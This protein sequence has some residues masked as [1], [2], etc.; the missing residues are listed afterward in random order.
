MA[1]A[2]GP[3]CFLY[4]LLL[5]QTHTLT[6]AHMHGCTHTLMYANLYPNIGR[7][8]WRLDCLTLS[9]TCCPHFAH[10]WEN[11]REATGTKLRDNSFHTSFLSPVSHQFLLFPWLQCEAVLGNLVLFL[12]MSLTPFQSPAWQKAQRPVQS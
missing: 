9:L 2:S 12:G 7:L 6:H 8:G 10:F 5:P 1:T 11:E 3:L 4:S